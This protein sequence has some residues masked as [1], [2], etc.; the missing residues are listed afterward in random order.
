MGLF[1]CIITAPIPWLDASVAIHTCLFTSYNPKA[2]LETIKCLRQ[3][4]ALSYFAY[5]CHATS[6]CIISHKGAV[7]SDNFGINLPRYV[8]IPRKVS[9]SFLFVGLGI[10]IAHYICSLVIQDLCSW[11]HDQEIVNNSQKTQI[12]SDWDVHQPHDTFWKIFET[13]IML[14]MIFSPNQNVVDCNFNTI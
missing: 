9:S 6:F 2:G 1:F 7:S 13:L 11:S 4:M 3:V 14:L 10:L 5:Q 12:F 8:I